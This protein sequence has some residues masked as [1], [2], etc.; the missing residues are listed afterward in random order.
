MAIDP[1][2]WDETYL[3]SLIGQT[4]D[5]K[6]EFKGVDTFTNPNTGRPQNNENIAA[7]LT[8]EVSAFA[9]AEGGT[10]VIG[11]KEDKSKPAKAEKL[12]GVDNTVM[13][14][15]RLQ[16]IVEHNMSP[17]LLGMRFRAIPLPVT[18]PGKNAFL[19][20]VPKGSNAYQSQ[21]KLYYIR[22]EFE[23][24]RLHDT[25]IRF[26]MS[27]GRT[28]QGLIALKY[29][30][31]RIAEKVYQDQI[32]SKVSQVQNSYRNITSSIQEQINKQI[33]EEQ[34][35]VK[36]EL[37]DEY[38]F[39]LELINVGEL[40][41]VECYLTLEFL[42]KNLNI[43]VG[44]PSPHGYKHLGVNKIQLSKES[45]PFSSK[46]E[47]VFPGMSVKF[48]DLGFGVKMPAGRTLRETEAKLKWTLYYD[49]SP[50][51]SEEI[52]LSEVDEF[53]NI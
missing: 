19:I 40:T 17:H 23:C 15:E 38:S 51:S 18:A 2:Y 47:K 53:K 3:L 48:S 5:Y 10:I 46:E 35:K 49:N 30:Q 33:A 29:P 14:I 42:F 34:A 6:L 24:N 43:P 28:M 4:E 36:K 50:A 32:S 9:N 52:I 31:P 26:L 21:E 37:Y 11:L 8:K 22:S 27:R 20:I 25:Q 45:F 41:I 1:L 39:S 7:N 16:R 12:D 13:D 44:Q